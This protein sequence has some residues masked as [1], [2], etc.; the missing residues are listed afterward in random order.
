MNLLKANSKDWG[1]QIKQAARRE[2]TLSLWQQL[3]GTSQLAQEEQYWTLGGDCCLRSKL[4]AGC[5][6]DFLISSGMCNS[7]Q[8]HSI[9]GNPVIHNRNLQLHSGH[10]YQGEFTEVFS[11]QF[12]E[13]VVT[14]TGVRIR[15]RIM[16]F[17]LN[18]VLQQLG[19]K[20]TNDRRAWL[21]PPP[22]MTVI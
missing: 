8:F 15:G 6:L 9:E 3:M 4:R 19:D 22:D 5:E 11:A 18:G 12:A 13:N 7:S 10:W 16:S 14:T 21:I 2:I 17:Q 1:S 20:T